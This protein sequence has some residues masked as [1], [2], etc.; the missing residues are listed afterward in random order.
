MKPHD[1]VFARIQLSR[2][3][4]VGVFA[5]R[6]IK[7][8]AYVFPDDKVK[9]VWVS[10]STLKG[11]PSALKRLYKDFCIIK[12]KGKTYGCPENFNKMTVS[13]YLNHSKKPNVGCDMHFDFFALRRIKAGEELTVDYDTFN[14][15]P[16]QDTS[17]KS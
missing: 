12:D 8:G 4:G 13:W 2:I 5:V 15:F 17:F 16:K 14:Q 10:R 1:G 9:I 7:N 6:N 11:L 3:H